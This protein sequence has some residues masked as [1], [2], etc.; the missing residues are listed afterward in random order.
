[1]NSMQFGDFKRLDITPFVEKYIDVAMGLVF[2]TIIML[3]VLPTPGFMLD[4]AIAANFSFSILLVA[5]AI[6]IKSTLDLATF[7]SLLLLTTLFRLGLA[8]ATTKGV[9]L[10]AHA[11][12]MVQVFG[13]LV[14]GGN[15]VVG[16]VVFLLLCTVQFVVVSKGSDRVA[17]VAARFTLDAIPGKQMSIDAD[18]R[19]GVISADQARERRQVLQQEIQL[20]GALDGAMKFVKGD[21]MVGLIV[22]LINIV[23]GI[24]VGVLQRHLP[25]HD[26][27]GTYV[28]LTV[29]DGLVSQIP[30]LMVSISAGL[31]ITRGDTDMSTDKNGNL[32]RRIY[33]QVASQPRPVLM[34]AV[35]A[36]LLA[37][38]P[39]FPHLQFMVIGLALLGIGTARRKREQVVASSRQA[40]M[41]NMA[42]DGSHYVPLL[43]DTVEFGTTVPLRIRVGRGA[44]NAIVPA[45]F[46]R[47]L[48]NIRQYLMQNLGL[49]FP[50]LSMVGEP[51]MHEPSYIIEVNDVAVMSGE[52]H[53]NELLVFGEPEMLKGCSHERPSLYPGSSEA[54]WVDEREAESARAAGAGVARPSEAL[55]A[56]IYAVCYRHATDFVGT[57]EA[58]FLLDRMR[59]TFPDLVTS[60]TGTVTATAFGRLLSDLLEE[61]ISIRNLRAICEAIMRMPPG[62]R[63]RHRLLEAA[64]IAV[65]PM[66]IGAYVDAETGTL[67]AIVIDE[68]WGMVLTNAL[69]TDVDGEPCLALGYN[70]LQG[71]QAA[72]RK[73]FEATYGS[74]VLL[75]SST[76][77]KHV[78]Q[79]AKQI[80]DKRYVL[81][82]EEI[83]VGTVTIDRVAVVER[84]NA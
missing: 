13:E 84:G 43:L 41:P 7:P 75:T 76:L 1:M 74:A 61:S 65:V 48:G 82:V 29:G 12:D 19:A 36:F 25:F 42:R 67:P 28:I 39:G 68:S 9:L 30:S 64:R 22:A 72:L 26:A 79:L 46:N 52:L 11:G 83:P 49:P 69:R 59:T 78:A 34:A 6:Y 35:M 55:A 62:D 63:S 70:D 18:L 2:L 47:E 32:G 77:R 50:G 58:Q 21:A 54:Y 17:E 80:D 27:V 81:A 37:V 3:L 16:L 45:D 33:D 57:Q 4:M 15:V 14:V 73:V 53:A 24:A 40:P 44:F 10:H 23:G 56:Q 51:S 38:V 31:V 60:L 71:F 66:G 20:H 5:V 8:V